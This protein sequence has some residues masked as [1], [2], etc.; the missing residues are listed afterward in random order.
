MDKT[1]LS[2]FNLLAALFTK[3]ECPQAFQWLASQVINMVNE[4]END[5][6]KNKL[7]RGHKIIKFLIRSNCCLLIKKKKNL[8]RNCIYIFIQ[9]YFIIDNK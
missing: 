8:N 7:L 1:H 4:K 3:M 9:W 2:C 6:Q 5:N